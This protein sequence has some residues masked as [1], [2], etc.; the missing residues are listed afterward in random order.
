MDSN[1]LVPVEVVR[2]DMGYGWGSYGVDCSVLSVQVQGVSGIDV[3]W[4]V[5]RPSVRWSRI[6]FSLSA[7]PSSTSN[8]SSSYP[9]AQV[10]TAYVVIYLNSRASNSIHTQHSPLSPIKFLH[11]ALSHRLSQLAQRLF[12]FPSS[13]QLL[14]LSFT[15]FLPKDRFTLHPLS[16]SILV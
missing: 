3:L 12:A 9:S 16:F 5:I 10:I 8:S 7:C 6:E 15:L 1:S 2:R 14:A 13:L 4:E 11:Q